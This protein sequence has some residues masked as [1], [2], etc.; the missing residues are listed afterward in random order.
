M[1]NFKTLNKGE[2]SEIYALLKSIVDWSI[3]GCDYELNILSDKKWTLNSIKH[4]SES[5]DLIEFT[6][7]NDSIV[8]VKHKGD[9]VTFT[10]SEIDNLSK[11]VFEK[12]TNETSKTFEIK[13]LNDFLSKAFNLKV[14]ESSLSKSD[15]KLSVVDKIISDRGFSVK[16]N[17]ASAP[18][19]L[20]ASQKTNFKFI[21][22]NNLT[23]CKSKPKEIIEDIGFENLVFDSMDCLTYFNN[24]QLIDS[25]M[26]EM[27]AHVIGYY[28]GKKGSKIKDLID[29][30]KVENPLKLSNLETYEIKIGDF[31]MATAFGMIPKL[32]WDQKYSADGGLIVVKENSDLATFYIIDQDL[33]MELRKYFIS[34][35]FLDTAS[36]SRH[37]FGKIFQEDMQNKI[38]LNLLIRLK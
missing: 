20:N 35:S 24:L 21:L 12:I 33:K 29:V 16:S 2:W 15:L 9:F 28:Y 27:L 26:P 5:N 8:R 22:K 34:N 25:Q 10:V 32:E 18:S 3:T 19:L 6:K 38:K 36:T 23:S 7:D 37:Q 13:E 11:I 4:N 30:L 14:K 31:L 1:S 17:L